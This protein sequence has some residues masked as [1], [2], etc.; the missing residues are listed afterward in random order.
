MAGGSF[1]GLRD[2]FEISVYIFFLQVYQS[3]KLPHVCIY[4]KRTV[5]QRYISSDASLAVLLYLTVRTTTLTKDTSISKY[6]L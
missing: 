4:L 5:L 3:S 6:V 1:Y 2:L